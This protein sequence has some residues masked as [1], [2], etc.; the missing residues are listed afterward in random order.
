MTDALS[1]A[2]ARA[3]AEAPQV[4]PSPAASPDTPSDPGKIVPDA[5]RR[6]EAIGAE[7]AIYRDALESA[8]PIGKV[9]RGEQVAYL[10]SIDRR[11]WI[12][13]RLVFDGGHWIKVRAKDGTQGWLPAAMLRERHTPGATRRSYA[14]PTSGSGRVAAFTS[15]QAGSDR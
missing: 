2:S 10:D 14:S 12:R 8:P 13:N 5:E 4:G 3:L 6:Y 7:V 11:I 15:P 9:V 1:G